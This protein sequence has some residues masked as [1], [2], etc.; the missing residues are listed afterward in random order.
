MNK[1]V[2]MRTTI[3]LNS[4]SQAE[5][6][7]VY[8]QGCPAHWFE[9]ILV[10]VDRTSPGYITL[11][12]ECRF[13]SPGVTK[14]RLEAGMW[15]CRFIHRALLAPSLTKTHPSLKQCHAK[16]SWWV[17]RNQAEQLQP[18]GSPMSLPSMPSCRTFWR[19]NGPLSRWRRRKHRSEGVAKC[20]WSSLKMSNWR[21]VWMEWKKV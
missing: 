19:R 4:T 9:F 10:Y 15:S 7:L 18:L 20:N 17:K 12:F 1:R 14:P 16:K 13:R 11:V 5:I 3:N 8:F 6:S 21:K 2:E